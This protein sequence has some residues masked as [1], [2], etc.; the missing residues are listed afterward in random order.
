MRKRVST[1]QREIETL[2]A[3]LRQARA[4]ELSSRSNESMGDTSSPGVWLEDDQIQEGEPLSDLTTKLNLK[5]I[6]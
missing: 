2:Q 3:A 5:W 4:V 6:S 1:M